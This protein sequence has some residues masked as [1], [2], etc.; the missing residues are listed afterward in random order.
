MLFAVIL[1]IASTI[2]INAQS[3]TTNA[4]LSLKAQLMKMDGKLYIFITDEKDVPYSNKDIT[5]TAKIKDAEGK[6]QKA[7][8]KPF[9]ETAFEFNKSVPDFK[10]IVATLH[11]KSTTQD[12][13]ITATFDG[14]GISENIYECPMHPSE[15][16]KSPGKCAK[17]GMSLVTKKV[18]TYHPPVIVRKGSR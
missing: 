13:I 15:M 3:N 8:L 14:K 6:K 4:D 5:A 2:T 18:T 7:S 12:L 17:C 1:L 9:G 10:Q 16:E 11:V